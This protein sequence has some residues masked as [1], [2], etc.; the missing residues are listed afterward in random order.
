MSSE[1]VIKAK[2]ARIA[3]RKLAN[4]STDVKNKALET[5]AH[6]LEVSYERILVENK[7]DI[8]RARQRGMSPAMIDRLTLTKER[9]LSM[10]EGVRQVAS[11]E[12]P[13]GHILSEQRR[14]NGL[15][16]RKITV[17][18]GV[19]A[20]IFE[21]RPNVTVD[22]A[23][24]CLKSGNACVLRGGS[25]AIHSNVVLVQVI[26]EALQKAGLPTAAVELIENTDRALVKELL[27]LRPYIDLAI[28]RGG[29]GLIQM[30]VNTATVP[31]IET[32]SG[33]CH[34]YVDKYA[35]LDMAVNIVENAKVSRP[36]T[37]NAME[38]LLVHEAVLVPF[39]EKLKPR[40]VQQQVELRGDAQI[41]ALGIEKA[42][43]EED[44]QTE[45][46]AL[47]LSIKAVPSLEAA[48][49]HIRQYSTHHSEA[50]VT[51]DKERAAMFLADVD[52]AAVY[53]NASTR[54]TDGF[55]FGFGAE[56][57]ISTQKLHVRGPMGLTALVSYKYQIQGQGQIR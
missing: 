15:L 21:S 2:E 31:C 7:K 36:S 9:V 41:Q 54:F 56:I 1:V 34:V 47:I 35:D 57:G 30:V 8:D 14:P 27:T 10:A 4:V 22:A 49:A 50:I 25:E 29:A 24:L 20:I 11:L 32:G 39:L 17:P 37:C 53:V 46:N 48:L 16:I 19:I 40:M 12:D 23:V 44:W 13:V 26:Q 55:E 28:P 38:T 45:Y 3:A 42:A 52:S 33:V 6:A 5:I 18:L 43:T 51:E